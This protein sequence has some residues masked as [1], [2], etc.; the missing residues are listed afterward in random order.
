[1][2]LVMQLREKILMGVMLTMTTLLTFLILLWAL[3]DPI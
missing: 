1:M 2:E 3:S